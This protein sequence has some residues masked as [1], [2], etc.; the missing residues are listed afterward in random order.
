MKSKYCTGRYNEDKFIDDLATK[1]GNIDTL[2]SFRQMFT[3]LSKLSSDKTELVDLKL[4]NSVIKEL[5][6]AFKIFTKYRD[7]KKVVMF[8]S[9]RLDPA[10]KEYKVAEEFSREISRKGFMVI[11][12]GGG[13]IM[14]AGNKGSLPGSSFAVNI[15]LPTEQAANAYI[16]GEKLVTLKYFF[17]RKLMFIKE[18]DATVLFP[19]GFGTHDEGFEVLTLLQT[20]K[21]PPRPLVFIDKKFGSYWR[22]WLVFIK[23]AL[24]KRGLIYPNDMSLFMVTDDVDEAVQFVSDFYRNYHSLRYIGD[25]TVIRLNNALTDHQLGRLNKKYKDILISGNIEACCPSPEEIKGADQL[26][27]FRLSMKFNR[28]SYGRLHELIHDINK[29]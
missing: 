5:R 22:D 29:L 21:T 25:R 24:L 18:S 27:Y 12:G 20:G 26:D 2:E 16:R 11:T 23:K 3:T 1:Y 14:E 13:G 7:K 19:G 9:H 8:G 10:S 15:K 4:I 28:F 6:Y 17:T